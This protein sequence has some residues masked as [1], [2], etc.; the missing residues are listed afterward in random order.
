[1]I[2]GSF[3]DIR[4]TEAASIGVL[5]LILH[6]KNYKAL[7][8]MRDT[9]IQEMKK[10]IMALQNSLSSTAA[11]LKNRRGLRLVIPPAGSTLYSH[12]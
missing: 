7:W 10:S 12:R 1:V 6:D 4:L 5:A 9:D 11:V 3:L 2:L 8:I